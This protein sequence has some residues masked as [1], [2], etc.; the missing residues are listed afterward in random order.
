LDNR[1]DKPDAMKPGEPPIRPDANA[2]ELP[3][4]AVRA[5]QPPVD[6]FDDDEPEAPPRFLSP[7]NI[8]LLLVF[9]ALVLYLSVKVQPSILQVWY[10]VKA[11]LGLSFIIFIH[12]LGHFLAAKWCGVNVSAF[13]IGFG[14]P[15]PGCWYKWGDTTY[16]LG[17]LPLG[18]YVQMVGQVDGDE[19]ADDE[20]DPRSYRKKTVPQRMLIISA[21]VVM[22]AIL[23]ALCFIYVYEG[24]GKEHPTAKVSYLDA[25]GPAYQAGLRT[26]ARISKIGD[27][28]DPTF[29]D[30]MQVVINSMSGQKIP[31]VFEKPGQPAQSISIEPRLAGSDSKP[32]IGV[33]APQRLKLVAKR[34]GGH[35]PFDAGTSAA[36]ADKFEYDDVIIGMSDPND[37]AKVTDLPPDPFAPDS[38]MR[39]YF[40]FTRRLQLLV[41]KEI[42]LRVQR[43]SG[44]KT[45]TVDVKVKPMYRYDLGVVMKMGPIKMVRQK[46]PAD[47][48][49]RIADSEKQKKADLIEAVTVAEADGTEIVYTGSTLDPE[50]LPVQ[51]KAWSARLDQAKFKGD[52]I[53]KLKVRRHQDGAQEFAMEDVNLVWDND[54]R[55]DR[56][57]A[58]SP[59]SPMAIPELGL[60]Y[61]IKSIVNHVRAKDSP[62]K[63]GD[64]IQN[65]RYELE[66][67]KEDDGK[68]DWLREDIEEG[69]WANVAFALLDVPHRFKKLEF[70]VKRSGEVQEIEVPFGIDE[71][72]PLPDRG[73][74]LSADVRRVQ[75]S[76]P[77]QAISMGLK[78]THNRMM[79]VFLNIR[80]M[81][82]GRIGVKNIGGPITIAVGAAH[83]ASL[84]W[85]EFVFFMGLIS[86]NLAVVN[87]LPIPIL[88][89][90]HMVFL[91]YEWIRRKPATEAVRIWATYA[92]L[93]I[94]GCLMIFVFTL[95][96]NRFVFRR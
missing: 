70:K 73:W 5:G 53:V 81:I 86:I 51:L 96:I 44:D 4:S 40:E 78:D 92:G 43:G 21:G 67:F 46:S 16:K 26:G 65:V 7:F 75:A 80:G 76:D 83:F 2:K 79:E 93:A 22:N 29:T 72:W 71:T 61:E 27:V 12:E 57:V 52:R 33:I 90:G 10:W 37:P 11:G 38:G 23:A 13:S 41:D 36:A 28:D 74:Y 69:Q 91:I 60:G 14:P 18:G 39:D 55:F 94:I 8:G 49:V 89:G 87:F 25:G 56:V 19:S 63:V 95:D 45:A 34:E 66:T 42:T 77:L 48:K 1:E 88:D 20:D 64:V 85:G 59:N 62:F 6:A 32:V 31:I 9:V 15:I 50:R 58:L 24:P 68:G 54:W 84:P 47:G 3:T 35:G 82:F 30:L 17:V